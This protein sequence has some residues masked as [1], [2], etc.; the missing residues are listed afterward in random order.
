MCRDV[1]GLD[2]PSR[3]VPSHHTC[4]SV[5]RESV[6]AALGDSQLRILPGR[7]EMKFNQHCIHLAAIS[8][9]PCERE[10]V[11]PLHASSCRRPGCAL[12]ARIRHLAGRNLAYDEWTI[13]SDAEPSTE[14]PVI[15]DCPPD[16]LYRGSQDDGL[17]NTVRHGQPPGCSSVARGNVK[18]NRKVAHHRTAN[19]TTDTLT[20]S[21]VRMAYNVCSGT[22]TAAKQT[23][24]YRP[25]SAT[26]ALRQYQPAPECLTFGNIVRKLN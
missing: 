8:M 1:F 25:E 24:R 23:G 9:R 22:K 20:G 14:L 26:S 5:G 7:L 10:M 4:A 19:R 13:E 6:E 15:S 16:P 2:V 21:E 18:H 12:M 3:F 17:M 11:G